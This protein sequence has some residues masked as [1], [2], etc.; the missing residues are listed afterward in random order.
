MSSGCSRASPTETVSDSVG[1]NIQEKEGRRQGSRSCS[2]AAEGKLH[3][4][5]TAA[6]GELRA[7]V[8]VA[9]FALSEHLA[10]VLSCAMG[11]VWGRTARK[12]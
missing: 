7:R 11:L 6:S 4:H 10:C 2:L 12:R 9:E 5:N 3:L 8:C 1:Q